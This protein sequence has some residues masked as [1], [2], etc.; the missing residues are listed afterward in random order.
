M[1]ETGKQARNAIKNIKKLT[2]WPEAEIA[3][4]LDVSRQTVALIRKGVTKNP[5]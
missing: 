5:T 4:R 2:G 3:R 1:I